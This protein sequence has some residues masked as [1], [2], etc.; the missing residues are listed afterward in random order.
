[1]KSREKQPAGTNLIWPEILVDPTIDYHTDLD[2]DTRYKI[3]LADQL[4]GWANCS[5]ELP[6]EK[7]GFGMIELS[8]I[9]KVATPEEVR[10][11]FDKLP[12]EKADGE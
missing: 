10:E 2:P 11:A 3:A 12:K 6:P 5:F 7:F 9:T 8:K 4:M 1:M